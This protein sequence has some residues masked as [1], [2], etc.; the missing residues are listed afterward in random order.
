MFE[1][2]RTTRITSPLSRHREL[3]LPSPIPVEIKFLYRLL[4]IASRRRITQ[5]FKNSRELNIHETFFIELLSNLNVQ[6]EIIIRHFF[7]SFF[8]F[9][10]GTRCTRLRKTRDGNSRDNFTYVQ[11]YRPSISFPSPVLLRRRINANVRRSP[12]RAKNSRRVY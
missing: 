9:L 8:F 7:F 3:P 11:F 10:E 1:A 12:R 5:R 2:N 6:R 4:V